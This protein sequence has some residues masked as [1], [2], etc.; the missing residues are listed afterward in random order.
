MSL[1]ESLLRT[2]ADVNARD[3]SKRTTLHLT[4]ESDHEDMQRVGNTLLR[5]ESGSQC[6]GREW[7]NAS[8]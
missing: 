4:Y 3:S 6:S 1:V 8:S 2:E 5:D 7:S